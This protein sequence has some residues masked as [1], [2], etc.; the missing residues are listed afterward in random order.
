MTDPMPTQNTLYLLSFVSIEVNLYCVMC[1]TITRQ[2]IN[3][4][5]PGPSHSLTGARQHLEYIC[6][7]DPSEYEN[8]CG[9]YYRIYARDQTNYLIDLSASITQRLR[10]LTSKGET[11]SVSVC[12][13][14]TKLHITHANSTEVSRLTD[15]PQPTSGEG[16]ARILME[17]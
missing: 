16:S 3:H 15:S 11:R 5:V 2:D 4:I 9:K 14:H 10:R 6:S 7:F 17:V 8:R 1:L 13:S 12:R